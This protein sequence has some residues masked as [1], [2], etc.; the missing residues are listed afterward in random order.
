MSIRLHELEILLTLVSD[1]AI[2]EPNSRLVI[3]ILVAVDLLLLVRPVRELLGVRPHGDLGWDMDQTEV[4]RL[5][6]PCISLLTI[7]E[8]ELE[9]S[10]VVTRQIIFRP[11]RELLVGGHERRR[12]VM[13][14]EVGL[15]VDVQQ[16]NDVV[17]VNDTTATSLGQGFGGNNLPIVVGVVMTIASDLLTC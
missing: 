13:C 7:Y 4:A 3:D 11:G 9:E 6:L 8:A 5:A 1:Y 15:R 14:H 16:L 12:D 17:V 10:I 2:N